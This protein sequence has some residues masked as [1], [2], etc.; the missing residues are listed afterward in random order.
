MANPTVGH[1]RMRLSGRK[2]DV[3]E[4]LKALELLPAL[5]QHRI[6]LSSVSRPYSNRDDDGER[7]YLDL[8]VL[9]EATTTVSAEPVSRSSRALP[10]RRRALSAGRRA[11]EPPS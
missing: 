8:F 5:T 9:D 1:V 2:E 7:R 3:Q 4:I 11:I 6:Q 10:A